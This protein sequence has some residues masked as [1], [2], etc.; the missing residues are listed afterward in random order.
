MHCCG[1]MITKKGHVLIVVAG[2]WNNESYLDSV[3]ILD[4]ISE[5]R[6]IPGM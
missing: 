3:E 2:G 6:W 1:K 4:P 5:N